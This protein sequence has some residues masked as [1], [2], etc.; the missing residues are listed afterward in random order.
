MRKREDT[1]TSVYTKGQCYPKRKIF[2][3]TLNTYR[4]KVQT[5]FSRMKIVGFWY[6]C[7]VEVNEGETV[8]TAKMGLKKFVKLISCGFFDVK[9]CIW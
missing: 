2:W 1:R 4:L 3:L 9:D 6:S 7:S 8:T 5:M